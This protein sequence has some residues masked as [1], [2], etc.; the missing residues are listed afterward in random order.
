MKTP[1]PV[2][3]QV[4]PAQRQLE[5]MLAGTASTVPAENPSALFHN[6]LHKSLPGVG[7]GGGRGREL[8]AAAALARYETRRRRRGRRK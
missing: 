5:E 8:R 4:D 7:S 2:P 6:D 3:A 1:A